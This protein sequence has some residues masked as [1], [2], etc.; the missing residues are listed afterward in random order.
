MTWKFGKMGRTASISIKKPDTI[1]S[2]F[3]TLNR[4]NE[5]TK[6]RRNQETK[7]HINQDIEKSRNEETL[8]L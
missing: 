7:K 2:I 8:K 4:R 1:F 6:K 5:E 3:Q